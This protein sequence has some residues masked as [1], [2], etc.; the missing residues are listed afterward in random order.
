M[1]RFS[2]LLLLQLKQYHISGRFSKRI[3]SFFPVQTEVTLAF[4]KLPA[5]WKLLFQL[6]YI[7][8]A[9]AFMD[10]ATQ[11]QAT[12]AP[13]NN[14]PFPRLPYFLRL[15]VTSFYGGEK[16]WTIEIEAEIPG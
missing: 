11:V 5:D 4:S 15:A 9:I 7:F 2:V 13:M 10:I 1:Y 16:G 14:F 8:H 6:T 12:I 3:H